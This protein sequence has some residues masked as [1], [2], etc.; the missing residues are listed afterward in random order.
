MRVHAWLLLLACA[1]AAPAG[2]AVT[3]EPRTIEARPARRRAPERPSP[4]VH[5]YESRDEAGDGIGLRSKESMWERHLERIPMGDLSVYTGSEYGRRDYHDNHA[6]GG[7]IGPGASQ[8]G[9]GYSSNRVNWEAV[10]RE[11]HRRR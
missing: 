2:D 4:I 11:R 8:Y 10:I 7:F 3:F 6:P 9:Q 1:A 5:P